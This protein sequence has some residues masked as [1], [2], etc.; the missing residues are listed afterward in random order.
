MSLNAWATIWNFHRKYQGAFQS[1]G[2]ETT[3]FWSHYLSSWF[4]LS[5]SLPHCRQHHESENGTL[6]QVAWPDSYKVKYTGWT[7]SHCPDFGDIWFSWEALVADWTNF[8][9]PPNSKTESSI[10][11]TTWPCP[12]DSKPLGELV[13]GTK[14][15]RWWVML[16]MILPVSAKN[17]T[18]NLHVTEFT[19]HSFSLPSQCLIVTLPRSW[20][21]KLFVSAWSLIKIGVVILCK[22]IFTRDLI[23]D[24]IIYQNRSQC[25][26][27]KQNLVSW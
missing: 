1:A 23:I 16:I 25:M 27:T 17:Q 7:L 6:T 3:S 21:R 26:M 15:E 5:L 19:H 8:Q 12:V 4:S 13:K 2:G 22:Y 14:F 10:A 18:S 24:N 20:I 9:N 11:K